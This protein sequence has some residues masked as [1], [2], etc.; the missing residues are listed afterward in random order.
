MW[1][2]VRG[3]VGSVKRSF[4]RMGDDAGGRRAICVG[5]AK[6]TGDGPLEERGG[7]ECVGAEG[8]EAGSND[9]EN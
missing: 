7:K 6:G 5:A 4:L 8:E 9:E 2:A 1:A 3:R